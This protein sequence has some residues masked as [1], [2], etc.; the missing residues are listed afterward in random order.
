[1]TTRCNG[2]CHPRS[3]STRLG[4]RFAKPDVEVS[5]RTPAPFRVV[6]SSLR[7][8]PASEK[9]ATAGYNRVAHYSRCLDVGSVCNYCQAMG[10]KS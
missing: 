2:A 4:A 1:M 8:A 5:A 3:Q 6:G 10:F 7:G 9:K